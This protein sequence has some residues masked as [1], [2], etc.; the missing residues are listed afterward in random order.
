M[1]RQKIE[2]ADTLKVDDGFKGKD[3]VEIISIKDIET[4]HGKKSVLTV[5]FD[6]AKYDVFINVDSNNNLVE[7]FG[8]EDTTWI[9]K[10]VNLVVEEDK[11]Y[12]NDKIVIKAI[13]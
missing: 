5:K 1:K 6:D 13:S 7:A 3:N 11:F 8:D 9:G 4:K 2:M 12:K 10:H